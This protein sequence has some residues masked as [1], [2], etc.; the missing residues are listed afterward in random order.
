ME[1]LQKIMANYGIA[2]RRKCE[3]IIKEGRVKVNGIKV[4]EMGVKVTSND[5]IEVDGRPIMKKPKL[6][7]YLL[8]KPVGYVTTVDDPQD[9]KTVLDLIPIKQRVFPVGRLDIM[10]SGLLLITN[11]GQLTYKLTHPKFTVK[12]TYK[13]LIDKNIKDE[14]IKKLKNG[15]NLEDGIT[16]PA[17]AKR[18]KEGKS[19]CEIELT[20]HEGKNRQVRRMINSLGYKVLKLERIKYGFLTLEGVKRGGY[21]ELK[22]EEVTKLY[23]LI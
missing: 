19:G 6:E 8:N 11:D 23:N 12:K 3:D 14:E 7:Y 9:R 15:I 1:R 4:T 2:S 17:M 18:L 22:A 20:I 13:V 5:K 10:T 16:A 21:R